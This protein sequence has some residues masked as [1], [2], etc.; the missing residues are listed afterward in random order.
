MPTILVAGTNT[1]GRNFQVASGLSTGGAPNAS[2]TTV[3]LGAAAG[4][5][6]VFSGNIALGTPNSGTTTYEAAALTVTAPASST[7]NFKGTITRNA[8]TVGNSDN[9]TK[10]GAGT[11]IFSNNVANNGTTAVSAGSLLMGNGTTGSAVG[12]TSANLT[13]ASGA[14]LGGYSAT[15]VTTPTVV[16]SGSVANF[17]IN[18]NLIVGTGTDAFSRLNLQAAPSGT[19]SFTNANLSFNLSSTSTDSNLLNLGTTEATFTNTVLTLNLLGTNVVTPGSVYTLI[20][21]QGDYFNLSTTEINGQAVI[22]GG[23]SIGNSAAFGA[24][25]GGF[26]TG[27]YAGSYLF[28]NG[29]D[30]DVQV[31]PEPGTWSLLAIGMAV[32]IFIQRWRRSDA[33]SARN[34][35]N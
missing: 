2:I 12:S 5:N 17:A 33:P 16:G 8:G 11:V 35:T 18:G 9:I 29:D 31:V 32:L 34:R 22:T 7:V 24:S 27:A 6:S 30:I 19:G 15:A 23:L 1:L 3:T 13:V 10:T 25:V 26:A 14:T 21:T 4:A 20:T 28:L